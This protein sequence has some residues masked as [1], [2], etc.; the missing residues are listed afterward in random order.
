MD[1]LG[2]S[3]AWVGIDLELPVAASAED[4][5]ADAPAADRAV[6]STIKEPS[7]GGN[8]AETRPGMIPFMRGFGLKL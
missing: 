6:D 7:L 2:V 8:I 4:E 5:N 1:C 3:G